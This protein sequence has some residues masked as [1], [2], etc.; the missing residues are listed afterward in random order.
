MCRYPEQW[1][2]LW[3]YRF[4][5]VSDLRLRELIWQRGSATTY[6]L[7]ESANLTIWLEFDGVFVADLHKVNHRRAQAED[8]LIVT[9]EFNGYR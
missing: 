1:K 2:I 7:R 6:R 5:R 8:V 4:G 9:S 3:N